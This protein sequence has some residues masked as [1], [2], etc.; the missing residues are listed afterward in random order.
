[1]MITKR[2]SK[3]TKPGAKVTGGLKG[4]KSIKYSAVMHASSH[5]GSKG[6]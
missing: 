3:G 6:Y 4:T 5:K 1:M 2:S